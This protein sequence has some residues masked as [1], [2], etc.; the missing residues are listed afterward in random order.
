MP[1]GHDHTTDLF[2]GGH[3]RTCAPRG[4]PTGRSCKRAWRPKSGRNTGNEGIRELASRLV[5][6]IMR[7]RAWMTLGVIDYEHDAFDNGYLKDEPVDCVSFDLTAHDRRVFQNHRPPGGP[8][9]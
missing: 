8:E 9:R 1:I 3:C 2:D 7:D 4:G 6:C 5:G